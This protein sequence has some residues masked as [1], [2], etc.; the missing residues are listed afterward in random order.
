MPGTN[1]IL[2]WHSEE[3]LP[4][5]MAPIPTRRREQF[6]QGV[7]RAWDDGECK[8]WVDTAHKGRGPFSIQAIPDNVR[9]QRISRA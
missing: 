8:F 4:D 9:R 1:A 7:Y 5:F 6:V 2:E 3:R